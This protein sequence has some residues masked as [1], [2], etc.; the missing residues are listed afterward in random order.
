MLKGAKIECERSCRHPV[1]L[2]FTRLFFRDLVSVAG[3]AGGLE[4]VRVCCNT[5][6]HL[7]GSVYLHYHR[8][9][10]AVAAAA[11]MHGRYYAG[12]VGGGG[13]DRGARMKRKVAHIAPISLSAAR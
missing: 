12:K 7:R 3:A 5:A 4:E 1:Y 6:A 10:D 9:S 11:S 8:T 2:F 13:G